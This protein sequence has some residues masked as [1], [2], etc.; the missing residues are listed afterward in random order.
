MRDILN[1]IKEKARA[2]PK[3]IVFPEAYDERILK[4]AEIIVREGIAHPFLVGDRQAMEQR[5]REIGVNTSGFEVRDPRYD[6][7][8]ERYAQ[9][10][11]TLRR[12]KGTT[13]EQAHETMRKPHYFGAMMV[14]L[15][16]ADGMVSGAHP[17]TKPFIPAFEIIQTKETFHKVSGVFL[18]VWSDGRLL[19]FADCSTEIEPDAKDLAE[20]A[21]DTAETAKRFGITPKIAMLSFS[22]HGSARHPV[23]DKMREATQIVQ[24]KRP[25]LIIDGEVQVDVALVPEVAKLKAPDSPIQGDANVLIFPDLDAGNIAYKLVE[26]LAKAHAIGPI[27]QGLQKPVN[28]LSR[29]C[30]VED[31]VDITAITVVEAQQFFY[32]PPC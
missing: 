6:T 25:E 22:T 20:I 11:Y 17:D 2:G 3:R 12:H 32:T 29:G 21:I 7:N 16:D 13:I 4:A 24:H 14:H 27:L 26:R 28:D 15:G 18:M 23:V 5:S 1:Q 31:I 9:E 8:F 10:Y 19:L 30:S